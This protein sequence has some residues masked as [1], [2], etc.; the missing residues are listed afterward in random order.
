MITT[1]RDQYIA[2]HVTPSVLKA[3][4]EDAVKSGQK[5]S[6]WMFKAIIEVLRQRGYQVS[7]DE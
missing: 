6:L 3:M 5:R 7:E 4:N 2:A 1:E